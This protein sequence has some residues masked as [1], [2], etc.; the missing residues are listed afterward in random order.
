CSRAAFFI[1]NRIPLQGVSFAVALAEQ[2]VPISLRIVEELLGS[3][4]PLDW[5]SQVVGNIAERADGA[6]AVT[7]LNRHRRITLR[8]DRIDEVL[9]MGNLRLVSSFSNFCCRRQQTL[10]RCL[11]VTTGDLNPPLVTPELHTFGLL[12][13]KWFLGHHHA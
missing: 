1:L 5:S 9:Q 13:I 11:K 12:L 7:N 8:P 3:R 2:P 10:I 6:G 4:I